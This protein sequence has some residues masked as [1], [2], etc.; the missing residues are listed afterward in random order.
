MHKIPMNIN[1]MAIAVPFFLFFIGLEYWFSKRLNRP[2]FN[3]NSSIANMNV[4][5]AERLIDMFTAAGFFFFYD[6]LHKHFAIFD[7]KPTLLLWIA[8]ILS[9]DL[10][11]YWYHRI[12]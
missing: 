7:I 9:T 1:Y 5:V 2:V 3:F 11:W 6:Y 8:L 12:W 10:I 4:G